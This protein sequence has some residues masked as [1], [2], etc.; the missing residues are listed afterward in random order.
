MVGGVNRSLHE[1]VVH[2]WDTVVR[3]VDLLPMH[4][5]RRSGGNGDKKERD[6]SSKGKKKRTW[7]STS[8]YGL[9]DSPT[10][11]TLNIMSTYIL[12]WVSFLAHLWLSLALNLFFL[13]TRPCI[14]HVFIPCI[15]HVFIHGDRVIIC[16]D[17]SKIKRRKEKEKRR[18][19]EDKKST[20]V[21]PRS[22][23]LHEERTNERT[24]KK[25]T[26]ARGRKRSHAS[27]A[28]SLPCQAA[29]ECA[30]P[31]VK[32]LPHHPFTLP[33]DVSRSPF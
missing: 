17:N 28:R 16:G 3:L 26:Q 20:S 21:A 22:A 33:T 9:F 13:T 15:C 14:C 31:R 32:A 2:S 27:D 4:L 30:A 5:Q 24:R 7:N 11:I 23:V 25:K 12:T 18:K 19:R 10:A 8:I 29:F 6:Q 1:A